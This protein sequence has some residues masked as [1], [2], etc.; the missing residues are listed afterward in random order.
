M[1]VWW[2]IIMTFICI[3]LMVSDPELTYPHIHLY[4][5]ST[6]C[7]WVLSLLSIAVIYNM[8]KSNVERKVFTSAYN[9]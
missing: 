9:V 5:I 3:S 2:Y 8:I 1:S 6:G 4:S 7:S